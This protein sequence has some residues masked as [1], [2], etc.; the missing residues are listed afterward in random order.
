[1]DVHILD[2]DFREIAILDT[3]ESLIWTDRYGSAGDF[4]IYTSIDYNLIN[5]CRQD[6]YLRIDDSEH[7]MIV[8]G[9]YIDSD[10]ESGN[11]LRITGHSLEI[12][13][14][15]RMVWVQTN[16]SGNLQNALKRLFNENLISPSIADRK[17]SNFI[18]QDST[19]ER[20]TSLTLEAEYT[21]DYLYDIVTSLCET[22]SMGFKVLLNESNQFVFQLYMG[23]DRSYD[24]EVLP[25]VVFSPKFENIIQSN[26]VDST[27]AMKNVALVAG[28]GEGTARRTLTV[29]SETGLLRREL[30]VDARDIQSDKVSNYNEALK[31]RGLE[32]LIE[33][34][35]TV[36]FEGQVEATKM[37]V[38]GR[39]FEMGDIIQIVNEY[40]IEG[41]ARVVEYIHSDDNTGHQVYPTFEAIQDIDTST[42]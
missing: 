2:T 29:G 19:D 21:G 32:Y 22:Y 6:Y 24:Q 30:Y 42:S 39:D 36:S 14:D 4:E 38:Y 35:K 8:E 28:E 12:L 34:A 40:G 3:Y 41:S 1:M 13:L 33:N 25:H 5:N 15:R 26:Y 23:T 31:Q 9:L 20:I 10:V 17:I 27:E 18:F 11:H 37:F 16:V 7:L